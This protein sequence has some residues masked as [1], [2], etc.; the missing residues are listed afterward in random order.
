M[1][2]QLIF[3]R[4]RRAGLLSA[5]LAERRAILLIAVRHHDATLARCALAQLGG[6]MGAW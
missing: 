6:L 5:Y 4:G 2:R 1:T 3:M